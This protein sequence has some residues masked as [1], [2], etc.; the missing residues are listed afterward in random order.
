[1]RAIDEI[2]DHEEISN[3]LKYHLLMQ[4]S[5]LLKTPFDSEKYLEI[6]NPVKDKL[7][8]V[9]VRLEDWLDACPEHTRSIVRESSSEMAYGMAK[10]AKAN[11]RIKSR[12]DLDD[13]TYYVAGLVGV[14]LSKL[15]DVCANVKTDR[16]L[17]IG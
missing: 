9:T 12:D 6:I 8:E 2:E 1:M 13:Y 5:D 16:D 3:D 17:A 11:W 4:I 14:M 15:W 7:P 10:W